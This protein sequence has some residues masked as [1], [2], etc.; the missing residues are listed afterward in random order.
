MYNVSN[1]L[2]SVAKLV[3]ISFGFK[4]I[5]IGFVTL[6]FQVGFLTLPKGGV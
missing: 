1:R 4:T 5:E 2:N 3:E 6:P